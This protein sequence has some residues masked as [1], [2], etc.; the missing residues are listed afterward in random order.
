MNP[1]STPDGADMPGP[2]SAGAS[3]SSS[4]FFYRAPPRSWLSRLH[5]ASGAC[6]QRDEMSSINP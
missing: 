2:H 5:R 6:Q 4:D 3:S 1:D